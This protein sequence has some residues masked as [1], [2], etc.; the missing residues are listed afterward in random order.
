[1]PLVWDETET[2]EF[3]PKC[4]PDEWYKLRRLVSR[5]LKAARKEAITVEASAEGEA[6]ANIDLSAFDGIRVLR[7]I[8]EW[9]HVRDG[10]P[11]PITLENLDRLDMPSYVELIAEVTRLNPLVATKAKGEGSSPIS[12]ASAA[13]RRKR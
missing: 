4:A 5:D 13:K 2:T 1:M 11:V 8:V 9:S 12:L 3:R 6:E 10:E 7:A